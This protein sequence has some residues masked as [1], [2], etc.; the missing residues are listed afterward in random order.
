MFYFK[1]NRQCHWYMTKASKEEWIGEGWCL[2]A[3]E[4]GWSTN[5][6]QLK[7]AQEA[8]KV[9]E[10]LWKDEWTCFS[11]LYSCILIMCSINFHFFFF[12]LSSLVEFRKSNPEPEILKLVAFI[13]T[14]FNSAEI[15]TKK[16]WLRKKP[17]ILNFR[18]IRRHTYR[19]IY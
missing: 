15:S 2:G 12:L 16:N 3:M 6:I 17:L 9:W 11:K 4:K 14:N 7:K 8:V 18:R 13:A 1:M 5:F 19:Y 10:Y